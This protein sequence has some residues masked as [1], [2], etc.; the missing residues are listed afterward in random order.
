MIEIP[1]PKILT[2][3]EFT[4]SV[5][6]LLE[7]EFPFVTISGEIS[8]LRR[9]YS[10]H[11]YLT[12][13]DESS[14]LKA[15]IFKTQQRYLVQQPEDGLEVICRGRISV[16]EPRGEYQLVI[17]YM[18]FKGTGNL[19]FAFEQLKR[20]LSA[21]GLFDQQNKQ[22]LP[23]VPQKV[24]LIT[25]PTGAAVHD[26]LKVAKKRLSSL[27][28]EIFPVRV[29]GD[30]AAGEIVEA[31]KILN[32]RKSSDVI[33]LCRGGGSIEDLWPF[34]EEKVARAIYNSSVPIVSAVGHEIDITIA[35][36]AADLRAPTPSAAAETIVPERKNLLER[37]DFLKNRLQ[38]EALYI[39]EENSRQIKILRQL[40]GDPRSIIAQ[41]IMRL[42]HNQSKLL[43]LFT[44]ALHQHTT[45]LNRLKSKLK[46][47]NPIQKL[48]FKKQW[49]REQVR[50][51]ELMMRLNISGK[52]Q[53]VDRALSLLEVVN[54][55]SVL[56][57]GYAVV[58]SETTGEVIRSSRQTYPG[59][60]LNVQLS[61]GR[62]GV[63]VTDVS[64][65]E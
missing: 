45:R 59:A 25:S 39:I 53:K 44:S 42:D 61:Q 63:D 28:I 19:Q 3:S 20:K 1:T 65:D 32:G 12:L 6:G 27:P 30:A 11:L 7:T 34:N 17:D 14:Q 58:R 22:E 50:Q 35:D 47:E 21:E 29:Q 49:T 43:H 60:S 38:T 37:I 15:V 62:I 16:Y 8:N 51:L 26:F 55:H 23:F 48:H 24:A 2:V 46:S 4:K 33:V 54:P 36:F 31:I 9:P 56:E 40:M 41:F 10:G 5:R 18:E 13:K 57:R 64:N 52:R